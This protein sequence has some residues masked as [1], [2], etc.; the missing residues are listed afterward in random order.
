MTG[1]APRH[2]RSH[3]VL[4]LSAL[5]VIG[6][7]LLVADFLDGQ[8]G[9]GHHTTTGSD[10]RS[11]VPQTVLNG[12]PVLDGLHPTTAGRRLPARTVAL[13]FD[14]GPSPYT[15]QILDILERNHVPA[16][17]F[18]IGSQVARHPDLLRRIISGGG[19][20][21]V[22]TFTHPHLGQVSRLRERLEIQQSEQVIAA[23]TGYTTDLLRLPYSSQAS[24]ITNSDWRAITRAGPFL[25]TF[26]DRDTDDWKSGVTPEA[27]LAAATPAA[28]DGAIVMM[29]DGG[30]D[31]SATVTALP[32][33]ITL[34]KQRG[35]QFRTVTESVGLAPAWQPASVNTR[36]RGS[37]SIA[38]VRGSQALVRLLSIFFVV[39]GALS[40]LRVLALLV[41]ARRHAGRPSVTAAWD[42]RDVPPV[43][44]VVPA[45]N[46]AIGITASVRSL[47]A[48]DYPQFEVIVVDDGSTD[49]TAAAV[50]AIADPRL[51][52]LRQSNA[53]KPAALNAGIAAARHDLLVLVDGDTV[54]ETSTLAALIAP[55]T[56][57]AVGAVSGNTKV[58]NRGGLLGKW[59]HIEYVIG[60]NLDR[61][62][63]DVLHCMPTIP[64]A[65]GAF[66]RQTLR[67]VGGISADTLAEDTDLTMAI[68]RS[69]WQVRYQPAAR[70]WTEAPANL[71][72]LWRQRYRWSYG[73]QQ[74]MWKHRHAIIERGPA[75]KLGRRGLPY[76][77]AFQVL[78][79]LLA[80]VI[81]IVGFYSLF[82]QD[83]ST[84][85]WAWLTLL[86]IQLAAA[87]YAFSLDRE[88]PRPLWALPL[89]Q[90]VY[91]QL[92]YLVVIQSVASAIYGARLGWHK[93][94]RTGNLESAPL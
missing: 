57:P 71:G 21:G 50:H 90:I 29:H 15:A 63:F 27:I 54:F 14:D 91:R 8:H 17:F 87:A 48:S 35:Y 70:A 3:W 31:R 73:T 40:V 28:E 16:T 10:S 88:S 86:A 39:V 1:A 9:E 13:T 94:R 67:D 65:I 93:L 12:G 81:D 47:L 43:S 84:L 56:D 64:G 74:A 26:A 51:Q 61:R 5:L 77:F 2:P 55:F 20:I 33:L 11:G 80:P 49:E 7:M 38:A 85:L 78:L 25:V 36:L 23:A 79:P 53:G 44:I 52:L 6:L 69:G 83:G 30:G 42:R 19:E 68:C 72:Q 82:T 22:H 4:L 58:G 89:Q 32:G 60:F 92:M 37:V 24:Q 66:R 76:L 41:F 62:M 45:Y 75:G 59:Q 34:L 18:V 46:E